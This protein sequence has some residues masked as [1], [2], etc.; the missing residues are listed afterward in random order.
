M[1]DQIALEINKILKQKWDIDKKDITIE[2]PTDNKWG[3]FATNVSMEIAKELKK[4]P[5]EI[6]KEL[7]AELIKD[8]DKN[9]FEKIETAQPGFINF[10]FSTKWLVK[11]M[12]I[13]ISKKDKYGTSS[14]GKG[15]KVLIEFSQP[16]PNKQLHIGHSRNNFLGSSLSNL[17]KFV[18]FNVI[19]AN[20]MNDWGT[21]ICKAMLMYKKYG[22]GKEPNKQPDHFVGD[23]YKMYNEKEDEN[24]QLKKEVAEMF[25]K[26]EAGDQETT[27]LWGKIIGWVKKG[28][29]TTYFNENV[30]F[31][32]WFNQSDYKNS[33]KEIVQL[34]V[35]KGV[36]EKD[37]TGA[38]I[39]RLEK[40]GI[41]DKVLLRSDGTSIYSTQDLQMAK[42]N[43]EKLG[44]EKRL[45][46][47]DSRQNDYFK[48]I[49]KILE[50]L[51]FNWVSGLY[52]VSYGMVSL[53]EG[54]VASRTGVAIDADEVFNKLVELEKEEIKTSLKKVGDL[55]GTAK[56]LALAAYRYGMLKVDPKS[57]V[58]FKYDRVTKFE[59]N[60]GPYL[61]YTYARANSVLEKDF[62][63]PKNGKM[64]VPNKSETEVLR[65]LYKFPEVILES[66]EKF[67]PNMLA[68]YLFTLAQKFNSFY[69]STPILKS[70]GNE[71]NFRINLTKAISQILKTGLGLLGIEVVEKM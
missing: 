59:G 45:Y 48:Q 8:L 63:S 46:V 5:M 2:H 70:D 49:F 44:L 7:S 50:I 66:T 69:S 40:Y 12:E 28:W 68:N 6:A 57:N 51:G 1:K 9:L 39:A 47:V 30:E 58:E 19:K 13:L 35:K 29:E 41:P 27:K 26:L 43:M 32:T 65:V 71:R 54:N 22:D 62:D 38:V 34:A 52:H 17:Y 55:E 31:D 11:E 61:L 24:P 20:Y 4:P 67:S 16:N 14:I 56:R 21:H 3:D 10:T 64:Y 36:A 15:K 25:S 60:T 37:E 53:P 42:D 33:G 18:G 23:F